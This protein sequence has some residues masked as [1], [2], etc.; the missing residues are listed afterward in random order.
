MEK[1]NIAE[2]L[3]DCPKGME[4]DCTMYDDLVFVEVDLEA[5]DYP[6]T[7]RLKN[8]TQ[9]WFTS[10]G[11]YELTNDAKC[12]IFPKGKTTWEGF[13]LPCQFNDGDVVTYKYE[14]ALVSMMLHK[15]VNFVEIHYHCALYDSAK[16]FITNNYI[17]GEPKYTRLATEEEKQKL[18]KAIEE[19]GYKWNAETKT[20]EKLP[21]FKVGDRIVHC[22]RGGKKLTIDG[23]YKTQYGI[24][25]LDYGI[26]I[27][28]QDE[29]ELVLN[30]F[31]VT[32]LK[33]FD[34]VLIRQTNSGKWGID[35]FGFYNE[36][37]YYTTGNCAY[38]QCIPYEGNEH[39]VGTTDDCDE[40]FKNW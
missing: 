20:L 37:Y 25:E 28:N 9:R 23:V 40:Y 11:R 38:L 13:V 15:F 3:K 34:K 1:I 10:D 8:G 5:K 27:E 6:I 24:K 7:T 31:D 26:P 21:K 39:L 16:G 18:F 19:N 32:T 33:P 12:V 29:Y 14:N 2:L 4:L 36:G 35:F 17:V 22:E 30:K